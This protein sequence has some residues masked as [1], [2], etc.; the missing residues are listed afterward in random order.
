MLTNEP[1]CKVLPNKDI[2]LYLVIFDQYK[3]LTCYSTSDNSSEMWTI[4]M[5]VSVMPFK[6][7]EWLHMMSVDTKAL[8]EEACC[9]CLYSTITCALCRCRWSFSDRWCLGE[10]GE[11]G[12]LWG[13]VGWWGQCFASEVLCPTHAPSAASA[14]TPASFVMLIK[15]T[16]TVF[17][18]SQWTRE[19]KRTSTEGWSRSLWPTV[20]SSLTSQGARN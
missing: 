6:V 11:E 14:P 2:Y 16:G 3:V 13:F 7:K 20:F 4:V 18:S 19:R 9:L 10:R 5:Y 1:Y 15:A 8:S 17:C 12:L